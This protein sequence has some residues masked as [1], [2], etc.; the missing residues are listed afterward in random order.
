MMKKHKEKF[1]LMLFVF[2]IGNSISLLAQSKLISIDVKNVNLEQFFAIIEKQ[3]DS[4][5]SYR[6]S[7]LDNNP[8]IT[9]KMD[10]APVDDI[11]NAVLPSKG[12]QHSTT[13]E[14]SIVITRK[15][16]IKTPVKEKLKRITGKVTDEKGETVIGANIQIEG[17]ATGTIT[18]FDGNFEIDVPANGSVTV[19]YIGYLTQTVKVADKSFLKINLKEDSKTLDEVVVVGYGTQKK[20]NLTGSVSMISA[21]DINARPVSSVSSGLQGLLPGVTIV[22]ATG[23]PGSESTTIRVRGLGTLGN[24]NPLILIDGVEG[25]MSTLNPEDIQSVSVLK[26]AAS[27][28]IY[29]ARAANGVLLITTK[30]LNAKDQAPTI[31][32]NSYYGT[33]T[34]TRLPEM[35]DAIE[36]M[37]LEN[38]AKRN[39]GTAISWQPEHFDYVKNGTKPNLFGNTDW[40]SSVLNS[41]APQQSYGV[42]VNGNVG[43]SGYMMSYRYFDQRGLTAG[44]STGEERH[45]IRFKLDSY[46]L[47]RVSITSNVSYTMR[48]ILAPV[49]GLTSDGGA[50][51]SAMRVSPNSPVYYTDGSWAYG[52][53]STNPVAVLFDGGN[54][55]ND[56]DEFSLLETLKIDLMKGWDISAT[57]SIVNNNS[58]SETLRKSIIFKNPD[59]AGTP[60]EIDYIYNN[61]N[62][63]SN[64]DYR[65]RQ[66]TLIVQSNFEFD[67]DKH[68]F[69]G[70]VGTSQ[71]W[72]VTRRFQASRLNLITESN[73]TLNLG[74]KE[75][76][77][78][79]ASASQWAIR[80]GFGR[81][82]YNFNDR[83]LLEMNTRVDLSSRFHKD[84]RTGVFPSFSAA[85][86]L[87]EESFMAPAKTLFD[88][89]KLRGSWGMLGNQYVGSTDYPYMSVINELDAI[90][91]LVGT[92]PTSGYT[93]T[94]LANP[95][96]TWEKIDMLD[97]G[98]DLTLLNNRLNVTFDWYNK[99]TNDILLQRNYPAQIGAKPSEENL[100]SVNNRGW[101][102]DLSWRD[103]IGKVQYGI[104]LNLSDVKN[105]ITDLGDTSPDLSSY[106]IRRVGDPIDAFYG[107]IAE[108]LLMP[109]DFSF[110][111]DYEEKYL[112]PK[113]P[114][115]IGNDYQPGDIKY[116]DISGPTGVPDGR[117]TPE[118]DRVVIG[119]AIPRYTY[120]VRGD[121][122][123]QNLDLSFSL[124]GVGKG[125][126][127]LEG[128]ARHAFQDMAAYPQKIHMERYNLVSNPNPNAS[129]PRLTY[130]TSF[131]QS[132]FS[133][134]W[135]EDASYL[136]LK[137]IQ[138]GY[139]LPTQMTRK[140]RINKCR[141]YASGDNLLT[142]SN[143][144]YAYDPESPISKG[145]Y[146][147]Q[148]K[149]FVVGLNI[150]FQ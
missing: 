34:P 72:S 60:N 99:N 113:V 29:G 125:D 102:I 97:L 123:W 73:P 133:T 25:D 50:I 38:E 110:Y 33:Q 88:N 46:L 93:Q 4:K 127:Y 115:I 75:G 16:E 48:N 40:I 79:D 22:N 8:D 2:L 109:E 140:V 143:F 131:N 132:N 104:A 49:G 1:L 84:N 86:R 47:D 78:N 87:S 101:E 37:T 85:W 89:I 145:G 35:A 107:Y 137:N 6:N 81:I 106:R 24:A 31:V 98:L 14:N 112:S 43:Q 103:K 150:T 32:F 74:S 45:N 82:N 116:R 17:T 39:V 28:A 141:L 91:S 55:K 41:N 66:Q 62:Q 92:N 149:T 56:V 5:F 71:E 119:S 117:I 121:I 138:I 21:D 27:S 18:D 12:L 139:T 53:G 51:Y 147:P 67:I 10:N 44:N 108:G 95:N 124:Q 135:L 42:S 76:M 3:S 136:R 54:T 20:V 57:Y 68:K 128:T 144:F 36:F 77:S 146:Y 118:Y 120:N 130:N 69:S 63:L 11:L 105:K 94:T 70:V 13:S 129:Y 23:Q 83:Y 142:F 58:L 30:K 64:T 100:G 19:S 90:L 52:I 15:A 111:D 26:D 126:G 59:N 148:V 80:S 65:Q 9:L 114:V 96:L 122:A 7:I 61:P 134:F